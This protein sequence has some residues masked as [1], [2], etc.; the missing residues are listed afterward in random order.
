MAYIFVKHKVADYNAWKSTF[1]AFIETRRAG[2]EKSFQILHPENEPNNLLLMFE[3]NSLENARN[4]M[5]SEELKN[6][7]KQAGVVEEPQS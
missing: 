1:D 4:F 2:G 3:W 6:A 5:T 7:M